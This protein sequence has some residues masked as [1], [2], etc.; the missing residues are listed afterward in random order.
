MPDLLGEPVE[1]ALHGEG[2]LVGAET[3]HGA[4][5]RVVGVDGARLDRDVG[6]PV[7]PQEWPAARSRTLAPTEA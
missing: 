6:H 7:G 3:A 5:R 2:G 4:A 1:D